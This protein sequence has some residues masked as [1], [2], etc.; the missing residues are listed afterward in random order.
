MTSPVWSI[1]SLDCKPNVEGLIDYVVVA[2]WNCTATEGQYSGRAYNTTTFEVDVDKP[3]YTPYADLTEAQVIQWVQA[4][5]GAETVAATEF[6]VLQQI[7]NQI[8][9]PIVTPALPWA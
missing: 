2:H 8:N 4:S 1:S 3:D 5:L 9:P 7:E 6:A